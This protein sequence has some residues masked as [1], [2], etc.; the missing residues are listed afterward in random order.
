VKVG[1]IATVGVRA[2]LGV[3]A[4]ASLVDCAA[5]DFAVNETANLTFATD[6]C[7]DGRVEAKGGVAKPLMIGAGGLPTA[8]NSKVGDRGRVEEG[9]IMDGLGRATARPP[10]PSGEGTEL[11]FRTVS[12]FSY[13]FPIKG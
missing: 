4:A 3:V 2:L 5:A 8:V 6:G 1:D 13:M 9:A 7:A 12:F 11:N 10:K